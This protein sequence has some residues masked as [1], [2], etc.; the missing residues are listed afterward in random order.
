VAAAI[1]PDET[2]AY[3]ANYGDGTVSEIDL[4]NVQKTRTIAV[5]SHPAS[6]TFDSNE[7]L[8]VG[9][10]GGVM[11]VNVSGWF[12]ASSRGGSGKLN[13][14]TGGRFSSRPV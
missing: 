5:M 10:Q 7:N 12:V 8:W 11:K 4:V 13:S 1:S 2:K 14:L 6:V 3:I 9:G